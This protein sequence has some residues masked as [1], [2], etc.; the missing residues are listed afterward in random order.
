[1][2]FIMHPTLDRISVL[3]GNCLETKVN[4]HVILYLNCVCFLLNLPFINYLNTCRDN[5]E[6]FKCQ[7]RK[8]N[9]G[10]SVLHEDPCIMEDVHLPRHTGMEV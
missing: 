6:N 7:H 9:T 4:R 3:K 10:N 8:Q 5:T 1:M 2:P